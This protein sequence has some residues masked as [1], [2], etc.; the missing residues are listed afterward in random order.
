[1]YRGSQTAKGV[2]RY[3]SLDSVADLANTEPVAQVLYA[4]DAGFHFTRS[5]LVSGVAG[6]PGQAHARRG[7]HWTFDAEAF[8]RCVRALREAPTAMG[9]ARGGGSGAGVPV[10][11]FAHGLGDPVHGDACV[12]P[13]HNIVLIEGNYLLLGASLDPEHATRVTD[14]PCVAQT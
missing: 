12:M 3:A 2:C 1:M 14:Y 6:D 13:H 10:P 7:A 11:T 8:V 5:Q 9:T 4:A